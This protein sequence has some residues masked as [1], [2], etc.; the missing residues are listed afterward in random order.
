[1]S[2]LLDGSAPDRQPI[3][4]EGLLNL[5]DEFNTKRSY[6][7]IRERY[8]PTQDVHTGELMMAKDWIGSGSR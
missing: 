8:K 5:I 1:M 7:G 2:K 4:R 3:G 6:M